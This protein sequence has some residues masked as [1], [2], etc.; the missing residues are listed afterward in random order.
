MSRYSKGFLDLQ[1]Q[2]A[3]RV[4]VLK[5]TELGPM[6]AEHTALRNL[7]NVSISLEDQ[8]DPTWQ[9][10]VNTVKSGGDD[11]AYEFYLAHPA[12][13]NDA[14]RLRFGCFYFVYPF[15]GTRV[16]RLHFE[17]RLGIPV[18]NRE[19]LALRQSELKSMFAYIHQ[20]H[21]EA[22]RVRGGSWMYHIEAYRRLFPPEYIAA[23][24]PV[25]YETGFFS[26]W[27]QFLRADGT[28]REPAAAQFLRC[29]EQQTSIDDYL[30]CFPYEVLRP[31]CS[32]DKFYQF[33]EV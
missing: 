24:V 7:L 28:V 32:I 31:E 25:G 1:I 14:N 33:Y 27:G 12:E 15:R 21:P 26:L 13:D 16:V 19:S 6:L 23:A 11:S 17:N 29:I 8:S 22:E 20:Q 5:H 2:F 10:F 3:Q 4:A 18:L 9:A 30:K